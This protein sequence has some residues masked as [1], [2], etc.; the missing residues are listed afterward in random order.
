MTKLHDLIQ[1][2]IPQINYLETDTTEAAEGQCTLWQQEDCTFLLDL[3]DHTANASI[4]KNIANKINWLEQNREYILNTLTD[5]FSGSLKNIS[6][7]YIAFFVE[8][9]HNIFCDFA[10]NCP[11]QQ[12][13][14]FSLEE[15]NEL[16]F[17]GFDTN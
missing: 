4:M 17:N 1:T 6:H 12:L 3:T 10:L 7:A 13:A 9:E 15:D 16:I 14:E 2:H 8:D 5:H 11:Q